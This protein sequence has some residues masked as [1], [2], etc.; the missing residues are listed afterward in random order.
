MTYPSFPKTVYLDSSYLI[1]LLTYQRD[2][3]D[4]RCRKCYS[5]YNHLK[6]EKVELVASL[7]TLEEVIYIL[8]FRYALLRNSP[9]KNIKEYKKKNLD[10]YV[11]KYRKYS[12]IP[13]RLVHECKT[14]GIQ[15]QTTPH[16]TFDPT[17]YIKEYAVKLLQKYSHLDSKDAF[18]IAV[19]RV[20]RIDMLIS[21]D[22]DFSKVQEIATF[23]PIK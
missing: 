8:F 4:K 12:G 15:I 18:H 6:K 2:R 22:D 21:C 20:L 7:F 10:D 17:L 11:K 16:P 23:N 19:A 1:R 3:N 13:K 9:Y 14:L 5:L